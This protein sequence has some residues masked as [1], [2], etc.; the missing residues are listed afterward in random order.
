MRLPAA[1]AL[2][3]AAAC[4]G[5]DADGGTGGDTPTPTPIS[6]EELRVVAM[7]QLQNAVAAEMRF[8]IDEGRFTEEVERLDGPPGM[9]P[10]DQTPEDPG[11]VAVEVCEDGSVVLLVTRAIEGTVLAVKA[12]GLEPASE[13]EAEFGHYTRHPP[14]DPSAGPQSWPGGYSV[15]RTGLQREGG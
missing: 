11:S 7:E 8:Y 15:S 4:G 2:A 1:L 14:C 3:A 5:G 13:G 6:R 9:I 10:S 12:R